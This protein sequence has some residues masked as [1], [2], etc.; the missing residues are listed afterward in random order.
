MMQVSPFCSFGF[1]LSSD[2]VLDSSLSFSFSASLSELSSPPLPSS[3]SSSASSLPSSASLSGAPNGLE[4]LSFL[5]A[6]PGF[7]KLV[8]RGP[9]RRLPNAPPPNAPPN[10]VVC[11][12]TP[13]KGDAAPVVD[14]PPK[15]SFGAASPV[16]DFAAPAPANADCDVADPV[17]NT[18]G[19]PEPPKAP[20]GE[21]DEE[22]SLPNADLA[23]AEAD[24]C[25][26]LSAGSF[27]VT[28]VTLSLLGGFSKLDLA[29][30][31]GDEGWHCK[32]VHPQA[33]GGIS[34]G[35]SPYLI[36]FIR[37]GI[38][39]MLVARPL[40]LGL[41]P[42]SPTRCHTAVAG[43]RSRVLASSSI[44]GV[45]VL[46]KLIMGALLLRGGY[47]LPQ[48][49]VAYPAH[50][51][52]G[53]FR[54]RRRCALLATLIVRRRYIACPGPSFLRNGCLLELSSGGSGLG[55]FFRASSVDVVGEFVRVL[56][57]VRHDVRVVG[58]WR[59]LAAA[60][61]A[62]FVSVQGQ[63]KAGAAQ[64][65][66]RADLIIRCLTKAVLKRRASVGRRRCLAKCWPLSC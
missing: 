52:V 24:G 5:N 48:L 22:A 11:P 35:A 43:F 27:E 49:V 51:R 10:P 18:L 38:I 33:S 45:L 64:E 57:I 46:I 41:Q 31:V 55:V 54:S 47:L 2:D 6:P 61:W 34:R 42:V 1:F 62:V 16:V 37:P 40:L 26:S 28:A 25:G 58:L 13:E 12:L 15:L 4:G 3:A 7:A 9:E 50:L 14:P 53:G 63:R 19:L 66:G 30:W 23:K 8:S 17:P 29:E 36:A 56:R 20:K 39:C 32:R 59:I 65:V 44:L 60:N 21:V